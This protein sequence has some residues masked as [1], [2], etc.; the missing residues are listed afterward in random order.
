LLITNMAQK[1]ER[2]TPPS[3]LS[4]VSLASSKEMPVKELNSR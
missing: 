1:P 4:G 3:S 2:A